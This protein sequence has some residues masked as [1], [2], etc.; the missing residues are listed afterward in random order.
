MHFCTWWA[1]GAM[2]KVTNLPSCQDDDIFY[3][4]LEI[5]QFE[6]NVLM[7]VCGLSLPFCGFFL[8]QTSIGF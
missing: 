4:C 3:D 1:F 5:S 6:I 2:V 8:L 7:C